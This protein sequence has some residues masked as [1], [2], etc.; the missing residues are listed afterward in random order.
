M[1]ILQNCII[2]FEGVPSLQGFHSLTP[3]FLDTLDFLRTLV[4]F[5]Y[6]YNSTNEAFFD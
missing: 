1:K 3:L 6:I 2:H 5:I 4:D